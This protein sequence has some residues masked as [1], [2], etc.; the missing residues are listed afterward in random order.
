MSYPWYSLTFVESEIAFRQ[1]AAWEHP[2]TGCDR[3][4][5][6]TQ[7]HFRLNPPGGHGFCLRAALLVGQRS[8]RDMLP[9]RVLRAGKIRSRKCQVISGTG[10]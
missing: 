8:T 2:P 5:T 6:P 10:H 9:P 3:A 1:G 7:G 4:A